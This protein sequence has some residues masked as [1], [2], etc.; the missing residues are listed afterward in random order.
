MKNGFCYNCQNIVTSECHVHEN[1][2]IGPIPEILKGKCRSCGEQWETD[3][4]CD[5]SRTL[6][7]N[8]CSCAYGFSKKNESGEC[9]FIIKEV[10]LS[11]DDDMPF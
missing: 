3:F 9:E 5:E 1:C 10:V 6:C 4:W 8:C 2:D 11:D 7:L